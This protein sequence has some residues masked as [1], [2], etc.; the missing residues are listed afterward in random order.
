MVSSEQ[1]A[2]RAP[3]VQI[4]GGGG[5]GGGGGEV[6]IIGDAATDI[7]ATA[8]ATAALAALISSGALSVRLVAGTAVAAHVIVDAAPTTAVTLAALPAL[9][10]GTAA[11]GKL[12]ANSGVDIGDVDV[13]S[14]SPPSAIFAAVKNVAVAGTREALGSTQALQRGVTIRARS[15]NTGLVYVGTAAA[16]SSTVY[17]D[18]LSPGQA[19]FIECNNLNLIGLDV[20]TS[21]DGVS[22]IAS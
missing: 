19:I 4:E 8:T 20:A 18:V 12:V 14:V 3:T 15:G 6:E 21:A 2:D 13:T 22:Y 11:I 16:V 10:A 7:D 17:G 5:G 9:V 1:M